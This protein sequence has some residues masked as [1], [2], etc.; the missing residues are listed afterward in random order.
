MFIYVYNDMSMNQINSV[1]ASKESQKLL[2]LACSQ[3]VLCPL[4][5]LGLFK[6]YEYISKIKNNES[7]VKYS[8][9]K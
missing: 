1:R 6:Q 3:D 5:L 9:I 7:P 4:K 8:T 2:V